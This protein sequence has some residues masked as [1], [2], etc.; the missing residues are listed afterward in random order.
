MDPES[1]FTFAYGETDRLYFHHAKDQANKTVGRPTDLFAGTCAVGAFVDLDSGT[2]TVG[3]LGDSRAVYG[4]LGEKVAAVELS[5]DHSCDHEGE[6]RRVREEHPGDYEAVINC[7]GDD[8]FPD[9][10][11]VKGVC[12]FT[13]SIGD[14]QMKEKDSATRYNEHTQ[15][16]KVVPRPGAIP[17][18]KTE[19]VKTYIVNEPTFTQFAAT[20]GFL[21]VACDGVWDEVSNDKA[22]KIVAQVRVSHPQEQRVAALLG[23][24]PPLTTAPAAL[25]TLA[26]L[27]CTCRQRLH[28]LLIVT[29]S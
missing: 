21:I 17:P 9:D 5:W 23:P 28:F 3:N 7:G 19:A 14:F 1:A 16:Y 25:A 18:D 15:G 6:R 29:V 20:D 26:T 27:C 13:R 12:S 11:R 2:I 4:V 10:W 22:V 24:P 8:G